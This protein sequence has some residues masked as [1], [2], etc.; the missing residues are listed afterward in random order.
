[1]VLARDVD[2]GLFC[3]VLG[4]VFVPEVANIGC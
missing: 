4:W 1:M 2:P 3:A